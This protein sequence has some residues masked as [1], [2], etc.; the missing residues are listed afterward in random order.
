MKAHG[1]ILIAKLKISGPI[2]NFKIFNPDSSTKVL[3]KIVFVFGICWFALSN[4]VPD[5]K[6][7]I[8]TALKAQSRGSF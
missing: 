4:E 8:K 1:I 2:M 7:R 5:F 6:I 3:Q